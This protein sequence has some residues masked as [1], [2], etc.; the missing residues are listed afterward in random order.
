MYLRRKSLNKQFKK[1]MVI[2][3]KTIPLFETY[4]LETIFTRIPFFGAI[5]IVALSSRGSYKKL[6]NINSY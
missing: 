2:I 4:S 5:V 6:E 1:I 3:R